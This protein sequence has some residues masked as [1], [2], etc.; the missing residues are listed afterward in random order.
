MD[1]LGCGFARAGGLARSA[2]ADGVGPA[3]E[4]QRGVLSSRVGSGFRLRDLGG[5]GFRGFRV[6]GL[7]L[8]DPKPLRPVWCTLIP[9]QSQTL[10]FWFPMKLDLARTIQQTIYVCTYIYIYT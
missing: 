6:Q 4:H 3:P 2:S 7:G 1:P 9:I 10:I 8:R 5:L